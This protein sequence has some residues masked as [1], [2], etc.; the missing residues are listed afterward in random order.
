MAV[1]V[2]F[3]RNSRR[4]EVDVLCEGAVNGGPSSVLNMACERCEDSFKDDEHRNAAL[5][6]LESRQTLS[7]A[8][9]RDLRVQ[10]ECTVCKLSS[11]CQAHG[12]A[13]SE[14]RCMCSRCSSV[15][16]SEVDILETPTREASNRA[17]H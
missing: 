17:T 5:Q 12:R 7:H 14:S 3:E 8:H 6:T 2:Q 15:R 1:G 13:D 9:E 10:S 11:A 4:E 16:R